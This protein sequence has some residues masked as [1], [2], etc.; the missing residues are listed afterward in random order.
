MSFKYILGK[1]LSHVKFTDGRHIV[2]THTD[3]SFIATPSPKFKTEIQSFAG[4][5]MKIQSRFWPSLYNKVYLLPMK[6]T[7]IWLSDLFSPDKT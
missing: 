6:R 4:L 2:H 1:K 7:M 5:C 3:K